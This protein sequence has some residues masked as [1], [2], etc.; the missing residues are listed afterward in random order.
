MRI[1]T[2]KKKA[3]EL[4]TLKP[5]TRDND[6]YLMYWIWKDE[7]NALDYGLEQDVILD[8]DKTNVINLLALLKDRK[9]SHPSGIMRA[10]RKL[11]EEYPKLRGDVWQ[12][13]H[14]EEEKVKEELGYKTPSDGGSI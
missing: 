3:A 7:F 4:L 6:F 13:R 14:T 1:L 5:E 11:Q 12:A 2:V 9:L 10:R 8:F